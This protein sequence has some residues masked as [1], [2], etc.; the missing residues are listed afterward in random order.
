MHLAFTVEKWNFDSILMLYSSQIL[1]ARC[2]LSYLTKIVDERKITFFSI[3]GVLIEL[4]ICQQLFSSSQNNP[5]SG[6]KLTPQDGVI[7]VQLFL[8][9]YWI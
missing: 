8:L 1:R 9:Q 6:V 5:V 7:L 3:V 2:Y 4:Y